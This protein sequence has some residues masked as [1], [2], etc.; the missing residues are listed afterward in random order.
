[1]KKVFEVF[2]LE[3]FLLHPSSLYVHTLRLQYD[4]LL[5]KII[6]TKYDAKV[7]LTYQRLHL[8]NSCQN[9]L[10]ISRAAFVLSPPISMHTNFFPLLHPTTFARERAPENIYLA[11]AGNLE[12]ELGDLEARTHATTVLNTR[13]V[14][15][16]C[17][18]RVYER[19]S[20]QIPHLALPPLSKYDRDGGRPCI[21]TTIRYRLEMI[22]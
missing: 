6:L 10:V 4:T 13:T 15:L 2:S 18:N 12:M 1:M 8:L 21:N 9:G 19:R 11:A 16:F 17:C 7:I 14:P 20:D 22:L 3:G 5:G